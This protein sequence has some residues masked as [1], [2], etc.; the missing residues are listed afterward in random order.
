MFK[1]ISLILFVIVFLNAVNGQTINSS[2]S[3]IVFNISNM[4]FGSVSGT[5]TGMSGDLSFY[6]EDLSNSSFEVC[7]DANT[8]DTENKKRDEHLKNEDFFEV[9]KYPTICFTSTEIAKTNT[10][11]KTIGTLNMHGISKAIEIP[12]TYNANVFDG[13]FTVN[14]IDYRI[15]PNGGF[16]VGKEVEIQIICKTN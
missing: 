11:Y 4:G 1:H 9:E 8:I 14:R 7:I 16:M 6:T 2:D 15:G 12:F 13:M 3:K 5:F 10:G